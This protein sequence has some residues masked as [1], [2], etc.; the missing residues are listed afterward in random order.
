[1]AAKHNIYTLAK[2]NC[3]GTESI[4]DAACP[5]QQLFDS[6]R[7]DKLIWC[8][9]SKDSDR[10]YSLPFCKR[11]KEISIILCDAAS[12]SKSIGHKCKDCDR[13]HH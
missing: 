9:A 7:D 6:G 4:G 1:M 8:L 13:S 12:S 3:D 2:N 10:G 5:W 11:A